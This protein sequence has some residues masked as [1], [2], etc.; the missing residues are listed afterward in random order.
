MSKQIINSHKLIYLVSKDFLVRAE[1]VA[2]TCI[3]SVKGL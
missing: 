3:K 2:D 1:D